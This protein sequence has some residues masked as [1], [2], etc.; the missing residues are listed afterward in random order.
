MLHLIEED[1][2]WWSENKK[3]VL[4]AA[5]IQ[6]FNCLIPVIS[7]VSLCFFQSWKKKKV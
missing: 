3:E 1:Q 5:F 6:H 2:K 4:K 7:E